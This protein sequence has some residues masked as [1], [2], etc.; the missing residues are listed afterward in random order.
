MMAMMVP[1]ARRWSKECNRA[2]GLHIYYIYSIRHTF[3]R[4]DPAAA[5]RGTWREEYYRH[6]VYTG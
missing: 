1:A 6:T 2:S 4:L 5:I 3:L